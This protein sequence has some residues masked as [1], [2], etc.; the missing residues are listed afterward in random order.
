MGTI[1][2]N[3]KSSVKKHLDNI[4]TILSELADTS[5]PMAQ[6]KCFSE[7]DEIEFYFPEFFKKIKSNMTKDERKIADDILNYYMFGISVKPKH[8]EFV[9]RDVVFTMEEN[10]TDILLDSD[11]SEIL[12]KL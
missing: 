4:L 7:R 10:V 8:Y 3:D 1:C 6:T 5:K 12:K 9:M 11:F 2:I